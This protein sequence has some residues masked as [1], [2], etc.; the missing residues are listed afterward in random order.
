[1]AH[2]H[3]GKKLLRTGPPQ[4]TADGRARPDVVIR[5]RRRD[6]FSSIELLIVAAILISLGAL[7][8][9]AYRS[10][11]TNVKIDLRDQ[12]FMSVE[13]QIKTDFDLILKGVDTGL[14]VPG[15][16]M[17][18]TAQSSCTDFVRALDVRLRN[19]RN[20]FDQT[21]TLT[22]S[23]DQGQY[24]KQGKVRLTCF[25]LWGAGASNGGA[26]PMH[27]AGIRVT[28]FRVSCSWRCGTSHCTYP[29]ADCRGHFTS[30]WSPT[31]QADLLLGKVE[32][33][34]LQMPGGGY[35]QG[36][37]GP[38][39]GLDYGKQKCG[40]GYRQESYPKEPDY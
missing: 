17:P 24:H 8:T 29:G 36:P 5:R 21:R 26:C 32:A 27:E 25:R 23:G 35:V 4:G 7:G 15:T 13:E 22:L 30:G 28:S 39:T 31:G 40:P 1:M 9:I 38:L 18:V 14:R 16:G 12:Q 34:Y 2:C 19:A 37:W 33:K 11:I 6:G 10:Y 3:T 20:P